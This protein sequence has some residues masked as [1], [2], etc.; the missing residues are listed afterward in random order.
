MASNEA[1]P[2]RR[3]LGRLWGKARHGAAMVAEQG[4]RRFARELLYQAE[5]ALHER[6]L[7][8]RTAQNVAL[9]EVGRENPD[10]VD[11]MPIGYG[12]L[13][14]ALGRVSVRP[15]QSVF[16]DFGTGKG[17]AVAVAATL[18][19]RRVIGVDF[20]EELLAQA[21][22]N[23]ARVRGRRCGEVQLHCADATTFAV[24]AEVDVVYFYNPF[25]G[26]TLVRVVDNLRASWQAHPRPLQIVF[27]NE[28]HFQR[29]VQGQGWLRRTF[30]ASYY[31]DT[32]C[33]IYRTG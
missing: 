16:L 10:S 33:G 20:S 27:F 24:P 4:P 29:L 21:R 22:Q 17:R 8:V 23:L 18:P 12:A 13:R 25:R 5:E 7:G 19:F 28:G 2:P 15:G 31:P 14:D 3:G 11:Y 6:R 1:T 32:S 26:P 9:G 30:S